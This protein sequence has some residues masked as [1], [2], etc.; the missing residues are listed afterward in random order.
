M[1]V[2]VTTTA[3]YLDAAETAV[4]LSTLLS[5]HISIPY[6]RVLA[7]RKQWRRMWHA[8][9]MHYRLDDIDLTGDAML[10]AQMWDG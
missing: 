8:Q 6:V 4:Y 5:R 2:N 10:E 9:R 3:Q 1:S 7:H